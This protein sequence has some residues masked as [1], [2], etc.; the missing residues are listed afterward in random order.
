[1]K[2]PAASPTMLG[3]KSTDAEP[4]PRDAAGHD[5]EW[6]DADRNFAAGIFALL[7]MLVHRFM[8]EDVI[9]PESLRDLLKL[10]VAANVNVIGDIAPRQLLAEVEKFITVRDSARFRRSVEIACEQGRLPSEGQG[11]A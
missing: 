1:M 9:E 8:M 10:H 4:A 3:G 7:S 5:R 11:S 2:A 6:T